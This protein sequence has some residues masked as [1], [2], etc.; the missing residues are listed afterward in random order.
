M[1]K[2]AKASRRS[3]ALSLL[4]ENANSDPK[5]FLLTSTVVWTCLH[6]TTHFVKVLN[7][8][9]VNLFKGSWNFS[10]LLVVIDVINSSLFF[11]HFHKSL[12]LTRLNHLPLS[13]WRQVMQP[14]VT[15]T[16]WICKQFFQD[17][18][19]CSH[20]LFTKQYLSRSHLACKYYTDLIHQPVSSTNQCFRLFQLYQLLCW[21]HRNE[22]HLK[23]QLGY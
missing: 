15:N 7:I 18:N 13:S 8:F 20:L 23:P 3:T 4:I 1:K 17:S 5:I 14:I 12:E 9:T 6:L 16:K 2:Y 22:Y 11:F 10:W 21:S 19:H